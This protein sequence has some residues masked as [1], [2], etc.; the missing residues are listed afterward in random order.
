MKESQTAL[1]PLVTM[2]EGKANNL[3][4]TASPIA[5]I[6]TNGFHQGNH[7][8]KQS[9]NHEP[10]ANRQNP[11]QFEAADKNFCTNLAF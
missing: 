6:G 7:H 2:T 10:G 8:R 5:T 3:G 4:T 11:R 1:A 9:A